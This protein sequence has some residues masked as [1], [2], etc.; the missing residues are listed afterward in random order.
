MI[1]YY[2]YYSHYYYY[3]S[4]NI[5]LAW[6]TFWF[7]LMCC[8]CVC[9]YAHIHR[10]IHMQISTSYRISNYYWHYYCYYY[11][12]LPSTP[13]QTTTSRMDAR[14]CCSKQ[15]RAGSKLTD[16]LTKLVQR[17]LFFVFNWSILLRMYILAWGVSEG[18]CFLKGS[19]TGYNPLSTSCRRP[20]WPA[21]SRL[22]VG[23]GRRQTRQTH[24][25]KL[26][27]IILTIIIITIICKTIL[28]Y[29]GAS[30]CRPGWC[31]GQLVL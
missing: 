30:P 18:W 16:L 3:H 24:L 31:R 22:L 27:T 17:F 28:C 25:W 13:P 20:Q 8:M 26:W 5:S 1:H 2:H 14:A 29:P 4:Q 7:E 15:H 6:V 11:M 9:L 12:P 10:Y 23:V 21:G 19:T